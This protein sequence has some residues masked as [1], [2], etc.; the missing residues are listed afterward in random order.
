MKKALIITLSIISLSSML[1]AAS[2]RGRQRNSRTG[3]N[4]LDI[5]SETR[6][7]AKSNMRV[8]EDGAL[9]MHQKSLQGKTSRRAVKSSVHLKKDGTPDLRYRENKE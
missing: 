6:P 3:L 4:T 7:A 8:N 9:A 1:F 5:K 2:K